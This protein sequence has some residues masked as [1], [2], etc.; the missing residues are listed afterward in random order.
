[1]E[2]RSLS[3][4]QTEKPRYDA[5]AAAETTVAG[6]EL[7]MDWT[8][9]GAACSDCGENV[10]RRWRDADGDSDQLVCIACK[11]WA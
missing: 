10:Q 6:V 3:D 8:P 4:F 5:E 9:E 2:D 11:Q 1:M 7:T